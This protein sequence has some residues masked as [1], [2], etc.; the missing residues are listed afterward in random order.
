MKKLIFL[1]AFF[2]AI[3]SGGLLFAQKNSDYK[4]IIN[5]N[6]SQTE[7]SKDDV[8]KIFLKK[9]TKWDDG[10][11]IKPV[12]LV[13]KSSVR[14]KFS[15]DIHDKDVSAIKAYWQKKIFSGKGVPPPEKSSDKDVVS[16]V[17]SNP[18]AIG[19]V[20]AKTKTSGVKEIEVT[21]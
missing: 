19:Y 3:L 15:K 6:N 7:I 9:I 17:K 4:I 20:A 18:G 5:K 11:K 8:S 1:T 10:N 14:K 12:D 21:D 16:Y 2:W 13:E